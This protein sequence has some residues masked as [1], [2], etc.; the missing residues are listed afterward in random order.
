M[1][2]TEK[3]VVDVVVANAGFPERVPLDAI[4]LE[5]F[6]MTFN[7]NVRGVLFNVQKARQLMTRGSIVLA[8]SV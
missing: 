7:I 3:G 4:I 1:T 6:H 8:S 5:R 2:S